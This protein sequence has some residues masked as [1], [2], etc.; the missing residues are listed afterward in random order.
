MAAQGQS[1]VPEMNISAAKSSVPDSLNYDERPYFILVGES[2]NAVAAG[3]YDTAAL[4]LIE[5]MSVEPA[6]PLNV[7]LMSNLGMIYYYDEKDS[8][9]L[10]TLDEAV[11]RAPRLIGA[12]EHRA[13]V[14]MGMGR[15]R[16][17]YD[18]YAAIIDIDSINTDARYYHGMM[19]L[20]AGD[21]KTAEADFA[22]MER[23][24]PVSRKNYMA[25]ATLFAMTGRDQQAIPLLRKLIDLEKMP[26]HYAQLAGC[27]IAVDNLDGASRTIGEGLSLFKEDPELLYYRA[28]L[29]KKRYMYADAVRDAMRA[30]E[31]GV[32]RAKLT[33]ILGPE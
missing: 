14:L 4:R 33:D 24:V 26:E 10:V 13:R 5:A 20:Y 19:A 7:A 29:N 1:R 6:N 3:D 8:L 27:L 21:L 22:I 30:V 18:E 17:A 9:A 32:S 15:D 12:R 28:I 23:V 11:R 25:H 16:D 2:E 31:L